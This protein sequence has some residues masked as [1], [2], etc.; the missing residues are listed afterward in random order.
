[1]FCNGKVPTQDDLRKIVGHLNKV[2]NP[3][4]LGIIS[5]AVNDNLSRTQEMVDLLVE[6]GVVRCDSVDSMAYHIV[7][8]PLVDEHLE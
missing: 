3:V 8:G 5:L 7:H 2:T 1:M 4:K 6:R